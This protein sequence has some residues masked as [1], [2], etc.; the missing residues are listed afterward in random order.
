MLSN[1]L[2]HE[3]ALGEIHKRHVQYLSALD[4]TPELSGDPQYDRLRNSLALKFPTFIN[5]VKLDGERNLFH[6][7]RGVVTIQTRNSKWY[8]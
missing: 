4:S 7:R 8:R 5:E 3:T 2:T 6:V 1:R